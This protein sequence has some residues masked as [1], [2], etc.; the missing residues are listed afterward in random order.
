[1]L[2]DDANPLAEVAFALSM[3]FFSLMVLM[4]FAIVHQ[5]EDM[6]ADKMLMTEMAPSQESPAEPQEPQI[7]IFHPSGFY[8]ADLKPVNPAQLDASKPVLLAVEETIPMSSIMGFK[9]EYAGFEIEIAELTAQ[10]KQAIT[11]QKNSVKG[12]GQ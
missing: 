4:L 2:A 8:D 6:V 1:M 11:S 10:W 9:R 7:L 12:A 5:P 3:A